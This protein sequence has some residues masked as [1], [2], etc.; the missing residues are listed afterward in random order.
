MEKE[1]PNSKFVG[2]STEII[3][4]SKIEGPL[5]DYLSPHGLLMKMLRMNFY[6]RKFSSYTF[7]PSYSN[8]NAD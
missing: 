7:I 1:A 5:T 6:C 4:Q 2:H 8:L 3:Q